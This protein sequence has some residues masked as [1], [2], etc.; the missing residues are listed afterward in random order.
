MG[1]SKT[2]AQSD[3]PYAILENVHKRRFFY[4]GSDSYECGCSHTATFFSL[5]SPSAF[6]KFRA[7]PLQRF[8]EREMPSWDTINDVQVQKTQ[9]GRLLIHRFGSAMGMGWTEMSRTGTWTRGP[10]CVGCAAERTEVLKGNVRETRSENR[11][12]VRVWLRAYRVCV[13]VCVCVRYF[14]MCCTRT[15]CVCMCVTQTDHTSEL[16]GRW[17]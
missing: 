3:S 1:E 7:N 9:H 17:R 13:C 11:V 5:F 6:F 12:S 14:R 10:G 8:C 15:V 4:F 2:K 16:L